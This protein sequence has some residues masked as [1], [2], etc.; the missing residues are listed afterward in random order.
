[1]RLTP[2]IISSVPTW[3]CR[4]EKKISGITF[5]VGLRKRMI[6]WNSAAQFEVSKASKIL[7]ADYHWGWNVRGDSQGPLQ[8]RTGNGTQWHSRS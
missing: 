7:T 4:V 3:T 8:L 5:V 1:M 2:R 6:L